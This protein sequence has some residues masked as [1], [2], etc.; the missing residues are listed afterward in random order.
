[1]FSGVND[2]F[3]VALFDILKLKI[4]LIRFRKGFMRFLPLGECPIPNYQGPSSAKAMADRPR[5]SQRP[6]SKDDGGFGVFRRLPSDN[7][8]FRRFQS[9]W[10]LIDYLAITGRGRYPHPMAA[11]KFA[12]DGPVVFRRLPSDK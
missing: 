12:A 4:G 8:A 1:M 2:T 9:G 5:K 3:G 6:I 11:E 7:V 10:F